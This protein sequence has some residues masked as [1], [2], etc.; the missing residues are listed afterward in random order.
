MVKMEL[1]LYR[2]NLS[3]VRVQLSKT[4]Y[5][6]AD[7]VLRSGTIKISEIQ[8]LHSVIA[9][10]WD[11]KH[12]PHI[13]GH[14]CINL[15]STI[16]DKLSIEL[17]ND[18]PCL[19]LYKAK[20]SE[21][22]DDRRGRF[23]ALKRFYLLE[24]FV[25]NLE[26]QDYRYN[27]VVFVN[28][29]LYYHD[30]E[31][32]V[33]QN[34]TA[35]HFISRRDYNHLLDESIFLCN[36]L[37]IYVP[38]YQQSAYMHS[39]ASYVNDLAISVVEGEIFHIDCQNN[40]RVKIGSN[41]YI[42]PYYE[43][44]CQPS[45]IQ[46]LL[47]GRRMRFIVVDWNIVSMRRY[48]NIYCTK[49]NAKIQKGEPLEGIIVSKRLANLVL[50]LGYGVRALLPV[51]KRYQ[52]VLFRQ[53]QVGDTI[54]VQGVQM[55]DSFYMNRVEGNRFFAQHPEIRMIVGVIVRFVR[56]GHK[57]FIV[58]ALGIS[59]FVS[60]E[61]ESTTHIYYGPGCYVILKRDDEGN[62]SLYKPLWQQYISFSY[63]SRADVSSIFNGQYQYQISFAYNEIVPLG[64]LVEVQPTCACTTVPGNLFYCAIKSL[65][66]EPTIVIPD[67]TGQ[68][69]N[70][71]IDFCKKH[72]LATPRVEYIPIEDSYLI[73]NYI[74]E[75]YPKPG[76][77][78]QLGNQI[79]FVVPKREVSPFQIFENEQIN[80][81]SF[82]LSISKQLNINLIFDE[83]WKL[84][85]L[86]FLVNHLFATRFQLLYYL[87]QHGFE[88]EKLLDKL[89]SHCITYNIFIQSDIQNEHRRSVRLYALNPYIVKKCRGIVGSHVVSHNAVYRLRD[90]VYIKA[91]LSI[92]QAY[93]YLLTQ[94]QNTPEVRFYSEFVQYIKPAT[95]EKGFVR[96]HLCCILPKQ[97]LLLFESVR[98]F[99]KTPYLSK[100]RR[101]Y[102]ESCIDKILRLSSFISE[103]SP[104]GTYKV[105][106]YLLCETPNHQKQLQ[107]MI[108]GDPRLHGLKEVQIHYI[109][110]MDTNLN[111]FN[112]QMC[113]FP[114]IDTNTEEIENGI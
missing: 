64:N 97:A 52:K 44:S 57:S 83:K 87:K 105:E 62:Y 66:P 38:G 27:Y 82:T 40:M 3:E 69:V 73:E 8:K 15:K 37:K 36:K 4:F 24:S 14:S 21:L 114:Q 71:G 48:R 96:I 92:N 72:G 61:C 9:N 70:V 19:N 63:V 85:V 78:I 25:S 56:K 13:V 94:Y 84:L 98:D 39:L 12:F 53:F 112:S 100:M 109:N 17:L 55:L 90:S 42:L 33:Y 67:F 32:V 104:W 77:P 58:V 107:S 46:L 80:I 10:K 7:R 5:Q 106:L 47:L 101:P 35:G 11:R 76:T 86:E 30:L 26:F 2:Y 16:I 113:L 41:V 22:H 23:L 1:R 18:F 89:I 111:N 74:L 110:D 99:T 59:E 103:R 81:S 31:A 91:A 93:L 20:I 6:I 54:L 95:A 79:K 108:Q 28:D 88:K 60:I 49:L 43:H 45:Y 50:D 102:P 34:E 68:M 65:G 51:D 75:I 29:S